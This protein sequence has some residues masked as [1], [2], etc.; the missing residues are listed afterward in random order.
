MNK[1]FHHV[2][3]KQPGLNKFFYEFEKKEIKNY[4]C[5]RI[6]ISG[7]ARSG[8]TSLLRELLNNDLTCSLTYKNMPLILA[9]NMQKL[10]GYFYKTTAD[11]VERSHQD[12][13]MI[14]STSPEAFDEV[15]FQVYESQSYT[16]N[17]HLNEYKS[18]H[19]NS[20]IEFIN[21][22]SIT[23]NKNI[24]IT[25]NNNHI[26]RLKQIIESKKFKIL[27]TF[28][29]P[30]THSASLEKQDL[31]H[32]NLQKKDFFILN[33]MN[34]LGHFEFG[35]NKKYFKFKNF[36]INVLDYD[37]INYWL[38]QWINYYDH[39]ISLT[40]KYPEINLINFDDWCSKNELLLK[41]ITLITGITLN[42]KDIY[43]P[44]IKPGQKVNENLLKIADNIFQELLLIYKKQIS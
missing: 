42:I 22:F 1:I 15:F 23:N 21:H 11:E 39:I 35:L 9:P 25:K 37:G 17:N 16:F 24:Y 10:L 20:Y 4:A 28:R 6:V 18:N 26:L 12:G 30:L 38:A 8:T 5:E 14:N 43:L 41:K 40:K 19:I 27:I 2:V 33:Y 29:D 7:L 32:S 44:A 3:F 36:K 34:Y 31:I 13:I